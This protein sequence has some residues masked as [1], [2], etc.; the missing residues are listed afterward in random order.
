M[1][2][3]PGGAR[4]RPRPAVRPHVRRPRPLPTATRLTL[5]V[6]AVLALAAG[7]LALRSAG[8]EDRAAGRDD[9]AELDRP[10]PPREA[11]ID[12]F[13]GAGPLAGA[14]AGALP[15]TVLEGGW[16]V[17][18][19]V[20]E[21]QGTSPSVAVVDAGSPSVV[22]DAQVVRAA[23]GSGLLVAE[24]PGDRVVLVVDDAGRG[25]HVVRTRAGVRSVVRQLQAPTADVVVQVVRRGADLQVTFDRTTSTVAL[26]DA[27]PTGTGV[28]LVGRGRTSFARFAYL[29]LDPS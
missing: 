16:T 1:S 23:A 24:G 12:P 20:A 2:E 5:A 25:W 21:P 15:W 26:P 4:P 28:G 17:A 13:D 27:P 6:V 22:I 18:D 29:P 14:R 9:L 3:R 11:P 10:L 7:A 8:A 19:G